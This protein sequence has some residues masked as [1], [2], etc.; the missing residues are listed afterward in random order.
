MV[1]DDSRTL[2]RI[3]L[4]V[5]GLLGLVTLGWMAAERGHMVMVNYLPYHRAAEAVLAGENLYT[6]THPD[7]PAYHFVYPPVTAI[8]WLPFT[9]APPVVGF[10]VQTVISVAFGL[11]IA[12]VSW[13]LVEAGGVE[14]TALDRTL[15]A[16]AA[17]ASSVSIPTLVYGNVN[18]VLAGLLAL[19]VWYHH[20]GRPV[21]AGVAFGLP[22]LVKAFPAAFGLWLLRM[23]R[24]RAV[25]AWMATGAGGLLAGVA[26]FGLDPTLTWVDEVL[27]PRT[28]PELFVG[29]LPDHAGYVSLRQPL[30]LAI[31]HDG[32][33]GTVLAIVLVAPVV[34]LLVS[35][36]SDV[37]GRL[38]ALLG[39]IGGTLLVLPTYYVYLV[40]L[41]PA[42]LPLA[43][44]LRDRV[45][46]RLFLAGMVLVAVTLT[47]ATAAPL[48]E[49]A[50]V[51]ASWLETA[52][53][54]ARPPLV[55]VVLV[56]AAGGFEAARRVNLS[57]QIRTAASHL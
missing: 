28:E 5:Y 9:L 51:V 49:V 2:P 33:L 6:V 18:I 3:V 10:G 44:L 31:G 4:A 39:I 36:A 47:P 35:R 26:V 43:Y 54:I 1:R 23:G 53:L 38:L 40:L 19:G 20:Q 32:L 16:W 11:A 41:L 12:V 45:A 57:E 52:M 55:G 14:L 17:V 56:L 42:M 15:L 27:L 25:L 34:V 46:S 48:A 22:G 29:G 8:G 50:P 24:G 21:A 30:A 37:T 13:R 7:A